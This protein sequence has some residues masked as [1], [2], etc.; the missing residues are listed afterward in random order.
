MTRSPYHPMT[1]MPN[2]WHMVLYPRADGDLAKFMQ[3][4]TLTHTPSQ[5]KEQIENIPYAIRRSRPYGSEG[6]LGSAAAQFGLQTTLRIGGRPR[7]RY[8]KR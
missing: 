4:I 6:W 3:R 8:Q 7:K 5:P 1:L 2:H